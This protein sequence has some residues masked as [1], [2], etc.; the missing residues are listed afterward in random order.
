[1]INTVVSFYNPQFL[2][3][4]HSQQEGKLKVSTNSLPVSWLYT[5]SLCFKYF[6]WHLLGRSMLPWQE[7]PGSESHRLTS[8]VWTRPLT[9]FTRNSCWLFE[10][11]AILGV[12]WKVVLGQDSSYS[13]TSLLTTVDHSSSFSNRFKRGPPLF[14]SSAISSSG[15]GETGLTQNRRRGLPQRLSFGFLICVTFSS[16]FRRN[17]TAP[18]FRSKNKAK[19]NRYNTPWIYA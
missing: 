16:S 1:M 7:S 8:T 2:C 13:P 19:H 4:I 14:S 12:Q 5:T 11:V 3:S 6:C 18:W 17:I 9:W 10:F 15:N